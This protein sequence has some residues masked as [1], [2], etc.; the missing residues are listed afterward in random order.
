MTDTNSHDD[1]LRTLL[2]TQRTPCPGCG[3]NLRGC[4]SG[5][6]PECGITLRLELVASRV[7]AAD[8][9]MATLGLAATT[10]FAFIITL[11]LSD[12]LI[13]V[14]DNPSIPRLV[15]I[16]VTPQSALPNWMALFTNAA[17]MS[18]TLTAL[19]W[20]LARRRRFAAVPV[21]RRIL[22]SVLGAASPV[23]LLGLTWFLGRTG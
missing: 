9:W 20:M 21:G 17:L 14:L 5:V 3:Y 1:A 18:L 6:C 12:K 23:I 7:A 10:V 4:E 15:G 13:T 11:R 16:G 8:W 19:G 2:S 22:I